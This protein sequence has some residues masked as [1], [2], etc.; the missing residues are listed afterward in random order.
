MRLTNSDNKWAS[1]REKGRPVN[2][3]PEDQL[4]VAIHNN[5]IMTI[6]KSTIMMQAIATIKKAMLSHTS[7]PEQILRLLK[8]TFVRS[9]LSYHYLSIAM[10]VVTRNY[11]PKL[12]NLYFK[13][14]LSDK[15]LLYEDENLKVGCLR[16]VSAE[17]RLITLKM[18][19]ANKSQTAAVEG[20]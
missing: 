9:T 18:F 5:S 11:D 15:F 13:S 3:N 17:W 4:M 7:N 8:R 14:V 12:D 19:L 10:Q 1:H 2:N 6:H 20:V 16:S